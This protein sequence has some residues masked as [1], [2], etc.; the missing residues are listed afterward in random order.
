MVIA[1][2]LLAVI[3]V[4][5]AIMQ[6]R[7]PMQSETAMVYLLTG[8]VSCIAAIEHPQIGIAI[9]WLITVIEALHL[10]SLFREE[11]RG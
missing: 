8:G 9:A 7:F 2:I 5:T 3:M 10:Y 11:K 6:W 1:L 4:M